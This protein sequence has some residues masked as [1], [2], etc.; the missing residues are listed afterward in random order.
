MLI[1]VVDASDRHAPEHRQ[2]VQK[3]LDDLGAGD[4]P[5]LVAYNKADLIEAAAVAIR[6]RRRP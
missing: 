4:K 3:V 5:R 6:M 1:E 2:T